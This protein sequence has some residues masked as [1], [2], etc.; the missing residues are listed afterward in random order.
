MARHDA[1]HHGT[2]QCSAPW[3]ATMQHTMARHKHAHIH[4][5]SIQHA[6]DSVP[7]HA[8]MQG[9]MARHE[10]AH[11]QTQHAAWHDHAHIGTARSTVQ[12]RTHRYSMQCMHIGTACSMALVRIMA[13]TH[14]RRYGMQHGRSTH[15][16]T[17]THT[18]MDT[19]CN[20]ARHEHAH[21]HRY[22]MQRAQNSTP[23]HA[24]GTTARTEHSCRSRDPNMQQRDKP[25]RG[26]HEDPGGDLWEALRT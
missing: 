24:H 3:H 17:N 22:S 2:P 1:V 16:G 12:A 18:H 11:I 25:A 13:R 23:W 26:T 5:Y 6:Q 15:H 10:H 7:W 9:T 21:I 19:A 20:M 4:R 8:T 14:T